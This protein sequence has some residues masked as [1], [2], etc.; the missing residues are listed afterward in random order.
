MSQAIPPVAVLVTHKVADYKTWKQAFDDH[1]PARQEASCVGH[2]VH[3]GI[4][5]PDTVTIYN[6]AADV[7]KLKAFLDG[8]E[9]PEAMLR[10]GVQ[11]APTVTLMKPMSASF[12]GDRLLPG[13]VV[14]HDVEDY[15]RWR[16]Y[17]DDFDERR[18][19][20]GI[21]N[22]AVNQVLGQPNRVVIYH[23]A[24]QIDTL[25]AFLES[26][27]LRDIM[28]AAGVVGAPDIRFVQSVDI[29]EY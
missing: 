8:T 10:A 3:R 23:Q 27:E 29:A 12:P 1:K 25:H 17:Y 26:A 15:D 13:I 6:P 4:D 19:Q 28:Q 11:G 22:H 21:V 7:D 24:E 9:L 18:K 14:T 16:T 20:L 2:D 5:D